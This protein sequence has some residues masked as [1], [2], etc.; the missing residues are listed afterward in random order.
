VAARDQGSLNSERI[1]QEFGS[2]GIDVVECRA[3]RRVAS[4]YSLQ[5]GARVC[6][7]YAD[8]AFNVSIL[9]ELAVEHALVLAGQSIGAVFKGY[10]WNITKHHTQVGSVTLTLGDA[11][12]LSLMR[13]E[14]PQQV[15]LH[16]YIFEVRKNGAIFDYAS[17]TERHHPQYLTAADL[18]AIYGAP[19]IRC[20][21]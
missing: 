3:E 15:A 9:P 5:S 20:R 12:I 13:L 17:I 10:G 21:A 19:S 4:L 14:A 1:E 2:F 6:R 11:G 8:V 16:S 18:Q 7:T